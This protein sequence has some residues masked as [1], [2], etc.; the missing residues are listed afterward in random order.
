MH[1]VQKEK[2]KIL[3]LMN[4]ISSYENKM[5][6]NELFQ[7]SIQFALDEVNE[8]EQEFNQFIQRV[9]HLEVF[10]EF[11]KHSLIDNFD[12]VSSNLKYMI[13]KNYT[14]EEKDNMPFE[15]LQ[16]VQST[17]EKRMRLLQNIARK[18]LSSQKKS[19]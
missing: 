4:H 7:Q 14:Q 18:Y 6:K 10:Q 2:E 3:N 11:L 17:Q 5:S 9:S 13:T 16:Q 1:D 8:M 12:K 15:V 19:E